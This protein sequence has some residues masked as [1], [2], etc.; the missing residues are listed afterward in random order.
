MLRDNKA[1]EAVVDD[2]QMSANSE[3]SGL[4]LGPGELRAARDMLEIVVKEGSLRM[5]STML[6]LPWT[7]QVDDPS[8]TSLLVLC[9]SCENPKMLEL[10]LSS[11]DDWSA[12]LEGG[13]AFTE[14]VRR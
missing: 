7:K 6:G 12:A 14:A 5:M 2:I 13:V 8:W 1:A 11:R 10:I 4:T 9:V 3:G